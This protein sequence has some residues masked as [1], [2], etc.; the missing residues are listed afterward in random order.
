MVIEDGILTTDVFVKQYGEDEL[1]KRIKKFD[2]YDPKNKKCLKK[3]R[4]YKKECNS[5]NTF[6]NS[7]A[8]SYSKLNYVKTYLLIMNNEIA[9]YTS[10]RMGELRYIKNFKTDHHFPKALN[11]TS[12]DDGGRYSSL[13]IDYFAIDKKYQHKYI[14][15][16]FMKKIFEIATS[17]AEQ[18][19]CT[20]LKISN[21]VESARGFYDKFKF[22]VPN[23]RNNNGTCD[24][25]MSMLEVR[26]TLTENKEH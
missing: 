20:I 19:G 8:H 17:L 7:N 22:T 2:C 11:N 13:I 15:S 4:K 9:G 14:G 16:S 25:A 12:L 1:E 10:L 26:E 24:L 21:A 18:A 23:S 5:I 6:L 3:Y